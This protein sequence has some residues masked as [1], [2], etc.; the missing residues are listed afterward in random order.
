M[1]RG[2]A[3]LPRRARPTP[4]AALLLALLLAVPLAAAQAGTL[5]MRAQPDEA[6]GVAGAA[7]NATLLVTNTGL[8]P[9]RVRFV[10]LEATPGLHVALPGELTV[11]PSQ[12]EDAPLLATANASGN[13][14]A[15]VRA[16]EQVGLGNGTNAATAELR[17][18]FTPPRTSATGNATNVT[19]PVVPAND[20][21][22]APPEDKEPRE[23]APATDNTRSAPPPR[24]SPERIELSARGGIATRFALRLQNPGDAEQLVNV[25]MRL[26]AGW[27]GG[28]AFASIFMGPRESRELVGH[29]IPR[30]DAT[31]GEALLLAEGASGAARAHLALRVEPPPRQEPPAPHPDVPP[32]VE[33]PVATDPAPQAPPPPKPTLRIEPAT[34]RIRAGQTGVLT[35]R[36]DNPTDAPLAGR[37][38]LDLDGAFVLTW[39]GRDFIVPPGR[40]ANVLVTVHAPLSLE[41][42]GEHAGRARAAHLAHDVLVRI[43]APTTSAAAI[44]AGADADGAWRIAGIGVAVGAGAVLTAAAWRRWPV[45]GLLPLYA[46]L[47]PRRA[48]EHP[49]RAA[50]L[51]LVQHEPGLTLADLQRRLDLPNG[52]LRHHVRLLEVAGMLRTVPDGALRRLYPTA[53]PRVAPTPG[54]GERALATLRAR[55]PMRASALAEE[56]G[57]SRQSLHYHL[58]RLEK[59][60]KVVSERGA[61]ELLVHA[62]AA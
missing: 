32:P 52:A 31:P 61:G 36:I 39:V 15:R 62:A 7:A 19:G 29:V 6:H 56:L 60:G 12:T 42:G 23:N 45:L 8:A 43:D 14:S 3:A 55:G 5:S 24:L 2:V 11:L 34:L 21:R 35:L 59:A 41:A 17:F 13:Y 26:P 25:S 33:E 28:L 47:Q 51:A 54:L 20:T 18:V 50:M 10:L 53:A 40:H 27:D 49:R 46:R 57:V 38:H 37:A 30:D 44:A 1:S 48:L 9:A 22:V 16:V 58:K 4:G